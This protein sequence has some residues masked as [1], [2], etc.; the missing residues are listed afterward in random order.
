MRG[1]RL[2]LTGDEARVQAA[3]DVV[4]QLA[5]LV[6]SGRPIEPKTVAASS[7]VEGAEPVRPMLDDVLWSHRQTVV[8]SSDRGAE[9]LRGRD[10]RAH[11]HLRHRARGHRQD[12]S[13]GRDRG[14][15]ARAR[16]VGRIILTRPAVEAGERLEFLPG[17]LAAKV[18]PYLPAAVRRPL[19]HAR[20]RA[21]RGRVRPRPDRGGAAGVHARVRTL[22]DSFIILDEAQNTT[23]EQM[24]MF[25]TRAWATARG[26]S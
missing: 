6:R 8:A 21:R 24:Q 22:S 3:A 26:W 4:E 13:R 2:T 15:G 7:A 25:L 16:L 10:P 9:A 11:D 12:L 14:R 18:D 19:R 5:V 23:R 20:R 1:N 17:D